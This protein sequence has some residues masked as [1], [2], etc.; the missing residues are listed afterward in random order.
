MIVNSFIS[1]FFLGMAGAIALEALKFVEYSGK[2]SEARFR[3]AL[4]SIKFWCSLAAL[5]LTAGFLTWAFFSNQEKVWAW[6]LVITGAAARSVM[7]D[8]IAAR[9]AKEAPHFGGPR[10][11]TTAPG[12]AS[13]PAQEE[14]TNRE[15]FL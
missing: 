13:Q 12:G 6:Q 4:R 14:I 15:I 7:R 1:F 3:K 11:Q 5:V 10:K 8:A 9:V 2:L